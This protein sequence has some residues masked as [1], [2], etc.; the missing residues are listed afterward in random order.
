[1][2]VKITLD[3]IFD[4]L[5]SRWKRIGQLAIQWIRKDAQESGIFQNDSK[6]SYRSPQYRKYKANNM[7]R[8]TDGKRLKT[9]YATSISS[10][11]TSFVN[12]TL[13]GQLFRGLKVREINKFGVTVGYD[14]K[15]AGKIIG[16]EKYGRQI[17]GL[18]KENI[19]K[20]KEELLQGLSEE[21]KKELKDININIQL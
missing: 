16:N 9:S 4:K 18:R 3:K 8:F 7:R 1:M 12:M 19:A 5:Q 20:V 6:D 21:I 2:A 11:E 13:T 10:N 14:P 17:V 15:D